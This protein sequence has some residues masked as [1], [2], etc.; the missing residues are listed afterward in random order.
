MDIYVS[1]KAPRGGD[2]T[3]AK[4]FKTIN[5]AAAIAEAGDTVVVGPGVYREWVDPQNGGTSDGCRVRYI[6]EEPLRL[7]VKRN[8][9]RDGKNQAGK[10]P[11]TV[12]SRFRGWVA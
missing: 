4:P 3:R 8:F 12:K 10:A 7:F 9:S 2:G 6:S 5:Q 11:W 1:A